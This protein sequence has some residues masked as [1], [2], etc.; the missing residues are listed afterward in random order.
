MKPTDYSLGMV[1]DSDGAYMPSPSSRCGCPD[2]MLFCS[3]MIGFFLLIAIAQRH[4]DFSWE[5]YCTVLPEPVKSVHSIP[6]PWVYAYG[7][8]RHSSKDAAADLK[9]GLRASGAQMPAGEISDDEGSEGKGDSDLDEDS[10]SEKSESSEKDDKIP[11]GIIKK[12]HEYMDK[13]IANAAEAG[14]DAKPQAPVRKKNIEEFTENLFLAR[15]GPRTARE[16]RR[17]DSR[18]EALHQ[19]FEARRIKKNMLAFYLKWFSLQRQARLLLPLPPL[20]DG[21]KEEDSDADY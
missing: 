19:A 9:D 15:S 21:E 17:I 11:L 16:Q 2:G 18:H 7:S 4:F 6:I 12:A 1:F 5:E 8:E 3:H 20:A 14:G 13:C 10:D